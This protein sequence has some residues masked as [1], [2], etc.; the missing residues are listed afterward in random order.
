MPVLYL[1][2]EAGGVPSRILDPDDCFLLA[3]LIM[4]DLEAGSLGVL[5]VLILALRRKWE[6]FWLRFILSLIKFFLV[7]FAC[8]DVVRSLLFL[9]LALF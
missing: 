1:A 4:G 3:S 2:G 7:V 5:S 6:K 8:L 9:R